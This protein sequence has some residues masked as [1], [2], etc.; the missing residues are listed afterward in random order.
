MK[1]KVPARVESNPE[2]YYCYQYYLT[3]E[4]RVTTRPCRICTDVISLYIFQS[5]SRKPVCRSSKPK[6]EM[7]VR[8]N[9][10][11]FAF[12]KNC[13]T[14]KTYLP[15]YHRVRKRWKTLDRGAL[16]LVD[17]LESSWSSWASTQTDLREATWRNL[18]SSRAQFTL[19]CWDWL[20]RPSCASIV[21]FWRCQPDY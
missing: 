11:L 4:F 10:R 15:F 21:L 5:T 12:H 1:W 16:D 20:K 14:K 2:K 6:P 9:V 7:L 19:R 3:F 18:A 13:M 17:L 8:P